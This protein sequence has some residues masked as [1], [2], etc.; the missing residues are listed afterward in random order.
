MTR[1]VL[2]VDDE[3]HVTEGLKRALRREPY[4]ILSAKSAHHAMEILARQPVDVVVSDEKMP[5]MSGSQFLTIVSQ[6]YP[7]TVRII[8][9]GHASLETAIRAI[10]E[11][12]IYRFLTKPCNEVD[13]AVTIRQALQ[14]KDL[15]AKSR[16][17]LEKARYQSA[18]LRELEEKHPGIARVKRT[19]SDAIIMGEETDSDLDRL[20]EEIKKSL[21]PKAG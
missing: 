16:R 12:K 9:T 7:D 19:S 14:L 4:E 8:L 17:V 21:R 6:R 3:P 13:L 10:N 5:G 18:V 2:F 11:G 15:M 1:K 20:M